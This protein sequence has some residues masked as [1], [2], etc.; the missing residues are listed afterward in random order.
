[1]CEHS[2]LYPQIPAAYR[3]LLGD[4]GLQLYLEHK[5]K[6]WDRLP[7][8]KP[9]ASWEEKYP[10][11]RLSN[12]LLKQAC[13]SGDVESELSIKQKLATDSGDCLELCERLIDLDRW[14][15][16]ERWLAKAKQW[17]KI[18]L[19]SS[20][21][22]FANTRLLEME[23]QFCLH[24]N[25]I[26]GALV[27]QWSIYQACHSVESYQ[28]LLELAERCDERGDWRQKVFDAL[29]KAIDSSKNYFL[30]NHLA[31]LV[32]L[33]IDEKE[34]DAALRI[35]EQYQVEDTTLYKV[36]SLFSEQPVVALPLYHRLIQY[37][38]NQANNTAYHRAVGLLQECQGIL[39]NQ[40]Q[41]KTFV[42][43][44]D[45]L[46]TQNKAKRNFMKYLGDAFQSL[47]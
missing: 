36:I 13:L 37:N 25:D 40:D 44:V 46:K 15:E 32:D 30:R 6:Q 19:K 14:D 43:I 28:Y 8:L 29:N 18:K 17:Q 47:V 2:S 42:S 7:P 11:S 38:I 1:M 16:S 27:L 20:P 33:Y 3:A 41:R 4:E 39:K 34:F 22:Y 23:Q 31:H 35:V 21:S 24:K 10:Y 9:H 12:D 5:Q 26:K 45:E